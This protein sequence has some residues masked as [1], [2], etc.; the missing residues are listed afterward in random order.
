MADLGELAVRHLQCWHPV[1]EGQF[2]SHWLRFQSSSCMWEGSTRWLK[3][4]GPAGHT[5]H[6]SAMPGSWLQPN[7]AWGSVVIRGVNPKLQQIAKTLSEKKLGG[8][9]GCCISVSL[10]ASCAHVPQMGAVGPTQKHPTEPPA[11]LQEREL[12]QRGSLPDPQLSP[13]TADTQLD[14]SWSSSS[15]FRLQGEQSRGQ[16]GTRSQPG[17]S[18]LWFI[19]TRRRNRTLHHEVSVY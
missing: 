9:G 10:K 4:L 11:K 8:G 14:V 13:P 6:P 7:P 18:S 5:E 3:G 2:E 15:P 17:H 16:E 1:S 19:L 12:G